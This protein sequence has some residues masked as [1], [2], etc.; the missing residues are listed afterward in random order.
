MHLRPCLAPLAVATLTLTPACDHKPSAPRSSSPGTTAPDQTTAGIGQVCTSVR[1]ALGP[2]LLSAVNNS[3]PADAELARHAA[4]IDRLIEATRSA[5]AD[6]GVDYTAGLATMIPHLGMTREL[7]RVLRADAARL[8]AAGDADGAAKRIAAILRLA[9]QLAKPAHTVI[10]VLV[11][12]ALAQTAA[13]FIAENPALAG[14]AWKTD[15]QNAIV[16]LNVADPFNSSAVVARDGEMVVR[17][18]REGKTVDM[19]SMGGRNWT[20]VSQA[21]RDAA[22]AKL[23][24]LNA[25]AVTAWTAP[26]AVTRLAAL[27]DR[28]Q[29]Q[30]VGDVFSRL[31]KARAAVDKTRD[32]LRRADAALSK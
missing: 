3:Q 9:A 17:A 14:A 11:A 6:F 26:D 31:D 18:L 28:A 19:S 4:D 1:E 27:A 23:Q 25:E 5:P 16:P 21:D 30:G 22:A 29:A 32:S 8:L 20:T 2:T 10:E 13:D 24:A 15:I 12:C 7:T